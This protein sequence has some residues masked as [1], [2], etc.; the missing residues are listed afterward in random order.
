MLFDYA[1]RDR[2]DK[3]VLL[4]A[5]EGHVILSAVERHFVLSAVEGH[6]LLSA[7]EGR[8]PKDKF[9]DEMLLL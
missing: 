2:Y 4:S 1:Q 8:K 3:Y 9:D 6:V 7:V 5:V